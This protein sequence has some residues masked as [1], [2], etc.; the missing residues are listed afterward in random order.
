MKSI[1]ATQGGRLSEPAT[2]SEPKSEEPKSEPKSDEPKSEEPSSEES[3]DGA[4]V[5]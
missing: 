1:R 2:Q 3:K 4:K 5:R